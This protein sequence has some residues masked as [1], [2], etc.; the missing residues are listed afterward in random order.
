MGL[1]VIGINLDCQRDIV[2]QDK[3]GDKQEIE[4]NIGRY[5]KNG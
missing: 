3:Q 2:K 5:T 4:T 1:K